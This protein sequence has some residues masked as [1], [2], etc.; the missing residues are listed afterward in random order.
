MGDRYADLV[1][2]L[3]DSVL[4]GPGV[5]SAYLRRG[6]HARVAARAG[7]RGGGVVPEGPAGLNSL[8]DKVAERAYEITD[9]DIDALRRAGYADDAI[10]EITVSAALGA[11][12]ARLERGLTVL[13]ETSD[14]S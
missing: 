5:T 14:A 2:R 1:H 12:L 13:R 11:G 4:A 10:F 6:V 7:G 9:E 8:V 3:R